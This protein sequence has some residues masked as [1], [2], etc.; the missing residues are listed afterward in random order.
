M[1]INQIIDEL[2]ALKSNIAEISEKV[3]NQLRADI[4]DND[5]NKLLT[6]FVSRYMENRNLRNKMISQDL[7]SDPCWDILMDVFSARLNDKNISVS[8][9]ATAG[10][11]PHTTGL[12]YIDTLEKI[13]YIY[14]E[15]DDWDGRRIFVKMSD[16]TFRM[17]KEYFLRVLQ[18]SQEYRYS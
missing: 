14:R 2:S 8:A 16:D 4:L 10:N 18:K 11:M 5:D 7:F 3:E 1:G 13:G 12:R 9:V 6:V 15:R 17:M